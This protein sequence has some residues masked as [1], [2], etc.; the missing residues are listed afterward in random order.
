MHSIC[1]YMIYYNIKHKRKYCQAQYFHDIFINL[2]AK[3]Q[4]ITKIFTVL[5][6]FSVYIVL[7]GPTSMHYVKNRTVNQQAPHS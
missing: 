1:Y 3:V 2:S 4:N 6:K 7:K 5:N